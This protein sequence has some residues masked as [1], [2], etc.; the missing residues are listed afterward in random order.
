M[1]KRRL[2]LIIMIL[3][4]VTGCNN[5]KNNAISNKDIE[6]KINVIVISGPLQSS[7]PYDYINENKD[8][9]NELLNSPKETFSYAITDLINTNA[10]DGLKS[11]IEALLCSEI[12]TNFIYDFES[13]SDYLNN[14]KIYLNGTDKLNEYDKYAKSLLK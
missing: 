1:K 4:T 7:N 8:I 3:I 5:I 13:A 2:L 9:Y 12:N 6:D 10:S 14:Y 11:Y